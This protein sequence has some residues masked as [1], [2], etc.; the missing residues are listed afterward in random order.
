MVQG[1]GDFQLS[2]QSLEGESV[3]RFDKSR[4]PLLPGSWYEYYQG[5]MTAEGDCV[6]TT[7]DTVRAEFGTIAVVRLTAVDRSS[8][9]YEVER[10]Y[11]NEMP[12]RDYSLG[13][14]DYSEESVE[15]LPCAEGEAERDTCGAEQ[16]SNSDHP[17]GEEPASP[18][19][20]DQLA[21]N[22]SVPIDLTDSNQSHYNLSYM[23][24]TVWEDPY[25][26]DVNLVR[27][28]SRSHTSGSTI[29]S[30]DCSRY[31]WKLSWWRISDT[32]PFDYY[33]CSVSSTWVDT[34]RSGHFY[35]D[36]FPACGFVHTYIDYNVSEVR[37][38][39]GDG[40]IG[41]VW[42]SGDWCADLLEWTKYETYDYFPASPP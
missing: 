24:E 22:P 31:R 6:Y 37:L 12:S 19:A 28:A 27:T 35:T 17:D 16:D 15:V 30:G 39:S 4:L 11:L 41:A 2:I 20:L 3:Q 23:H 34:V 29:V 25:Y 40:W 8:C 7:P 10:G 1:P 21:M 36:A 5:G 38:T 26:L 32:P 9:V 18:I 33:D 42:A 13:T 14:S